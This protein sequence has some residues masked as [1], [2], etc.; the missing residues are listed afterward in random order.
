MSINSKKWTK[1]G[2]PKR[3]LAIRMHAMGDVI[4]TLPYLQ[5]LRNNLPGSVQIDLLTRY[6]T[7]PIPK[8]LIL[9]DKI[10]S[11][12]GKRNLKAIKFF[13]FLLLPKLLLRRYD[14]VI[15]LQNNRLSR[16][17]RK[18]INPAAWAEF[19][20]TSPIPAGQRT[21]NT[22]DAIG[23]NKNKAA[24]KLFLKNDLNA[25]QILLDN[26]WDG[27]KDLVVLNPAGVF[28]TRNWPIE[29]Y[30]SFAKL[31]LKEFPYTQFIIIGIS[32]I[33]DKADLLRNELKENIICL[34]DKTNIAEAFA[35]LQQTKFVLS[36]DS[37]LMHMSWV[38]GKPTFGLLGG[39]RPDRGQPEGKFS[40]FLD[41]SDLE[42]GCC[43][44]EKCKWGDTRC[45]TRY[46]PEFV[47]E[48]AKELIS[49]S[50]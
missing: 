40:A 4:I 9:F 47:F 2:S 33:K 7:D 48:K 3:I 46:S 12:A 39:T 17:I 27:K 20:S 38:S 6:E 26:G 44:Q 16:T 14:I 21:K 50:K 29:N 41:S 34:I 42:C 11:V 32:F 43:M 30:I 49:K 13:T 22:I 8:N 36:E 45:L 25:K 35:I 23:L 24:D 31:W 37:G 1:P 5:D 18:I 28:E 19:D 15:D 10:F